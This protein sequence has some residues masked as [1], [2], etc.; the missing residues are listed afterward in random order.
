MAACPDGLHSFG[1][2]NLHIIDRK[3]CK[4]C[5]SC[6]AT[7]SGA[8]KMCGREMS[9]SEVMSVVERDAA[10]YKNSGGGMTVSGGEPLMHPTFT[11]ALA[12]AAKA[13]GIH[14]AIETSGYAKWDVIASLISYVDLFLWDVKE[15]DDIRHREY[16]GVSREPIL[17]NLRRLSA[18]GARI[19]LRCPIIPSL[20]DRDAHLENIGRLADELVGVVRVDVEPYHPLG[21]SKA[22]AL[23]KD[24]P[25]EDLTF[26]ADEKTKEWISKI[27]KFTSKPVQKG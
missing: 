20:N 14:T 4:L 7:C 1:E 18:A 6:E 15:T 21:K 24:Y 11:L 17:E 10:F 2:G 16:T 22:L 9:V 12:K 23:G 13:R 26:P 8:I 25:L 5:G 3:K 27:S 19:A